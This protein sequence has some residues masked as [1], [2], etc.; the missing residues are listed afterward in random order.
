MLLV[1]PPMTNFKMTVG[2][3][4]IVSTSSPLLHPIKALAH[5]SSVCVCVCVFG[6]GS[7]G[8]LSDRCSLPPPTPASWLPVSKIKQPFLCTNLASVLAFEHLATGHH[9]WLHWEEWRL[10]K[11]KR[12]WEWSCHE[13]GYCPIRRTPESSLAL[14]LPCEDTRRSLPPR[15]G[16]SP[17]LASWSQ[18]PSP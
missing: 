8:Q 6:G 2:A 12:S 4:Y 17:E 9:F 15:R 10:W 7:G 1:R 3:D 5:W 13:W 14:L 16:S 18:T 11:G